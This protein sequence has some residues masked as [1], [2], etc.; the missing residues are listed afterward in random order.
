MADSDRIEYDEFS[1][2][3][4]NAEEF[5]IAYPGPPVV[6]REFVDLPDGRVSSALR[7]GDASPELVLLH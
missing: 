7:W 6:R 4:E 3:H 1:M 2:F 5:G